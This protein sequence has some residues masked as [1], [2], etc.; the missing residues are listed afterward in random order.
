M[1]SKET[2]LA[3]RRLKE[4]WP[5]LV[6]D[7]CEDRAHEYKQSAPWPALQTHIAVTSMAMA[8]LRDGG[9]IV[10]GV[11]QGQNGALHPDGMSDADLATFDA[12]DVQAHVNKYADSH[13]SLACDIMTHA[14]KAFYVIEVSQFE[15]DPV[16]CKKALQGS[17]DKGTIYAR[18]PGKPESRPAT[19]DDLREII[20]LA[21]E[22]VARRFLQMAG[23]VGLPAPPT[24][25]TDSQRFDEELGEL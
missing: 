19:H 11:R 2:S 24:A 14:G 23:R 15:S 9:F 6:T 8:N 5:A 1:P 17:I 21:S 10:I 13:V 22:S 4:S 20:S 7:P 3:S 16:M 25:P 18:S 12:D